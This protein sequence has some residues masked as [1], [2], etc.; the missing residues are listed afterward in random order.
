MAELQLPSDDEGFDCAP[1]SLNLPACSQQPFNPQFC[2]PSDVEDA[3]EDYDG[4]MLVPDDLPLPPCVDSDL[5][6]ACD[7]SDEEFGPRPFGKSAFQLP[8]KKIFICQR[9]NKNL[10]QLQHVKPCCCGCVAKF[11]SQDGPME[12][13]S[14][15]NIPQAIVTFHKQ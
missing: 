3:W 4:P 10:L 11:L 15:G 6:G 8:E 9:N 7:D 2:L 13:V 1:Y 12:N 14:Y 5:E